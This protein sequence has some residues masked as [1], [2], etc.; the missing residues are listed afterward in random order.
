M[1]DQTDQL[2][3]RIAELESVID[4]VTAWEPIVYTIAPELGGLMA[5]MYRAKDVRE[6]K[7]D[8]SRNKE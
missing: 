4:Q 3:A 7:L 1:T 6:K 8:D 2:K 5:A